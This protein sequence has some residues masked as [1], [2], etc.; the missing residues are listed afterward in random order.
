MFDQNIILKILKISS[1]RTPRNS[2]VGP[3]G[4]TKAKEELR[5][6]KTVCHKWNLIKGSIQEILHLGLRGELKALVTTC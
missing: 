4:Y 1:L 5:A 3:E 2:K 6:L